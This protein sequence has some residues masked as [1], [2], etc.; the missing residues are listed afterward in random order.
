[1]TEE[2]IKIRLLSPGAAPAEYSAVYFVVPCEKG[3]MCIMNNHAPIAAVVA[4]G[5]MRIIC[6]EGTKKIPV[7]G[8]FMCVRNN[9]AEIFEDA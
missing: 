8:G 2:N 4:E 3:E 9:L 1:M 7:K 6:G 5:E